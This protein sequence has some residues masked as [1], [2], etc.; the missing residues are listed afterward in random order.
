MAAAGACHGGPRNHAKP[1]GDDDDD[2]DSCD[3]DNDD[4]DDG[5]E[6]L[7][8]EDAQPVWA[9]GSACHADGGAHEP[10]DHTGSS[11]NRRWASG[12]HRGGECQRHAG[13][14]S[15]RLS[16]ALP[17]RECEPGDE[18]NAQVE[19]VQVRGMQVAPLQ[20]GED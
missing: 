5:E 9:E 15:E 18:G 11:P 4:D 1:H 7:G 2:A 20:P 12:W 6:D 14:L 8:L 16:V 10:A 19:G 17:S 3:D 13:R